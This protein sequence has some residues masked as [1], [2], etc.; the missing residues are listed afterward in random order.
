M[1]QYVLFA[2]VKME[3]MQDVMWLLPAKL[4]ATNAGLGI[5]MEE[6]IHP[7]KTLLR[8]HSAPPRG[9]GLVCDPSSIISG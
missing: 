1:Y 5:W 6:Y 9:R 3:R 2:V 7:Y 8:N 4:L